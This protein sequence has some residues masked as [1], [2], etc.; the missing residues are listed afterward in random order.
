MQPGKGYATIRVRNI[1]IR[2]TTCAHGITIKYIHILYLTKYTLVAI[3][4]KY[5]IM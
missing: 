3:I 1:Y 5:N 4:K 2:Q